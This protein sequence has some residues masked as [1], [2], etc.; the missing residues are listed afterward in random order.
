MTHSSAY[1]EVYVY[2]MDRPG[3]LLQHVADAQ[4]A[5]CATDETKPIA[6]V[7][8]LV[9]LYLH[10]ERG[11]TGHE[12]QGVHARMGR[13]RRRWSKI[14]L[15]EWRG[16]FTAADVLEATPGQERDEA[17]ESWCREVWASYSG[18]WDV[19]ATI[20]DHYRG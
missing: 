20:A 9:G 5:Q 8:S 16:T 17:I 1:D 7:F 2:A 11:M 15:P 14:V 10:L 18:S 19:I 13:D 6:L 3:F 4:V 12:V